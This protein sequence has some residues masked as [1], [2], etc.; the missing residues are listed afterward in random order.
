MPNLKTVLS[1]AF[2]LALTLG[3]LLALELAARRMVEPLVTASIAARVQAVQ[4]TTSAEVYPAWASQGECGPTGSSSTLP[5]PMGDGLIADGATSPLQSAYSP[6]VLRFGGYS[7]PRFQPATA[8]R[9]IAVFGASV[10]AGDGIACPDF[11]LPNQLQHAFRQAS[12]G[13]ETRV[14]NLGQS[15][16]VAQNQK[17]LLLD[18]LSRGY[19]PDVVIFYQGHNDA[20]NSAALGIPHFGYSGAAVGSTGAITLRYAIRDSLL[21]RS[22]LLRLLTGQQP[23]SSGHIV[24]GP[25]GAPALYT[26]TYM[27]LVASEAIRA[28]AAKV[29][30]RMRLDADFIAMLGRDFGFKFVVAN[31]PS[32]LDRRNPVAN[33]IKATEML[34]A[35][36]PELLFALESTQ[37][38]MLGALANGPFTFWDTRSCVADSPA[39]VFKDLSHMTAY[40]YSVMAQCLYG[41]LESMDK[42][43]G[44]PR[45]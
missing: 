10:V 22:A 27:Q 41:L 21:A 6:S 12:N 24:E 7:E 33:E 30:D 39:Q 34:K 25:D 11:V 8:K 3:L 9:V 17:L 32:L 16:Y 44:S 1:V 35:G 37:T 42:L 2:I 38:A 29:G 18:L 14:D 36:A 13:G 45:Q 23:I 5:S 15:A 28:R 31:V 43:A 40:G 20:L 26:G 19:R 4:P